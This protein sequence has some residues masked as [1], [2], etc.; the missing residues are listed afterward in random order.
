M[1]LIERYIF[2]KAAYAALIV[3]GAL[4][5]VVWVVQALREIDIIASNG[6][7]IWTFLSITFLVVPNLA[8]AIVPLALLIAAVNTINTMNA[9]S[10]LV[11]VSASG[12]SNWTIAKPLL[13]LALL[14][15]L[16]TGLVAHVISPY[17][18]QKVKLLVT[19][20]KADLV[21]VVLQE[22]TFNTIEDGLTFHVGERGA[23]GLLSNIVISD[24]REANVSAVYSAKEG[25]V[26]RTGF[27]SFLI[28]KDGEI[29][30]TDHKEQSVTLIKYQSYAFDLSSF[31]GKST[32]P[33][34]R[35]KERPTWQL[36]SPDPRT[37]EYQDNPGRFRQQIHERFSEMLWPF[38]N[39][40]MILAFSG[41]ARSSRQNFGSAIATAVVLLVIA[42]GIGFSAV[43]AL[44]SDP[45]AVI[46]AYGVPL[47][48]IAFGA[49]CVI[50]NKPA[51]LP[52]QLSQRLDRF[53]GHILAQVE[54]LNTAYKLYRRRRAGVST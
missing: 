24:D 38:A 11:V 46:Y 22:G 20:M 6:Q 27:G 9:N 5:G 13:V 16:F 31:S 39:V 28:L 48:C 29:Q 12:C 30:Q 51:Q 17:S 43:S 21:S 52:K 23:A 26:T 47:S 14:C 32:A 54:Q 45:T 10:E 33:K 8:Q 1:R 40:L 2:G 36:L 19:E 44:K 53:N 49:Y 4:V 15:S 41:Q 18:L 37:K 50:T 35:I 7:S 34:T 42:R 3:L 25:I